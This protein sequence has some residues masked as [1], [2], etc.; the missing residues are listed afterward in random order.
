[1][2]ATPEVVEHHPR[3]NP[4]N[5][6]S[7]EGGAV[8]Q[9]T[10]NLADLAA[11]CTSIAQ[12]VRALGFPVTGASYKRVGDMLRA[13]SIDTSHFTKRH[14]SN[15]GREPAT[16]LV[17]RERGRERAAAL[18]R[19][20]IESGV[21]YLCALC[22]QGRHWNGLELTLQVDHISGDYLDCRLGNLRFLCPNCHTQTETYG[23]R[24]QPVR[25]AKGFLTP[26]RVREIRSLWLDRST[27]E[28]TARQL[29]DR[30]G[31]TTAMI[32]HVISGRKWSDVA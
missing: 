13:G 28:I 14:G 5:F 6:D 24:L 30:Y 22:G 9:P 23:R 2:E 16:V 21:P 29:A 11:E 19:A 15:A 4:L 18:R 7:A 10:Q 25:Q 20:M 1:M 32:Y 31:V 17:V 27:N 12:V 8:T 3:S 26:G